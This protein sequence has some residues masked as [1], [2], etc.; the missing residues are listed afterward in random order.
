ML[1][2]RMRMLVSH[3]MVKVLGRLYQCTVL[4]AG[5]ATRAA[6]LKAAVI[7]HA[8]CAPSALVARAASA[9]NDEKR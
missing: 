7:E 1:M 2:I 5:L 4:G 6:V 8:H 9:S 3:Y